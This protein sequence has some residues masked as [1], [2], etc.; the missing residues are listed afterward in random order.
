MES[1]IWIKFL[2]FI[3][4]SYT[5]RFKESVSGLVMGYIGGRNIC[6][7]DIPPELVHTWIGV[8]AW[9]KTVFFAFSS[10]LATAYAAYL[11]EK[12]KENKR[13]RPESRK[14]KNKKTA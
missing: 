5:K 8:W 9:I 11:V 3:Y 7:V 6:W 4:T 1:N 13:K 2:R 10:S 14:I 12:H